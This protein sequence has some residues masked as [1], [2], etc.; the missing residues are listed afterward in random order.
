MNWDLHIASPD[1]C[2]LYIIVDSVKE[3]K[4]GNLSVDKGVGRQLQ[5]NFVEGES[6]G[7][8]TERSKNV[9]M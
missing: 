9:R 4:N 7:L 1:A 6:F 3:G 8:A 5:K 2:T